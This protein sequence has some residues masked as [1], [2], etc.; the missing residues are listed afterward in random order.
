ML[1]CPE[2]Q[3]TFTKKKSLNKHIAIHINKDVNKKKEGKIE[4]M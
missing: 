1:C 3:L 2:C 4:I